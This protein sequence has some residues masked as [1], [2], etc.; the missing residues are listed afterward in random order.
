MFSGVDYLAA[1]WLGRA[2]PVGGTTD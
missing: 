2:F 1:Y